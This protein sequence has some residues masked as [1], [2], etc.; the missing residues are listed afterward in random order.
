MENSLWCHWANYYVQIVP[1]VATWPNHLA[2]NPLQIWGRSWPICWCTQMWHLSVLGWYTINMFCSI[3]TSLHIS[4]VNLDTNHKSLLLMILLGSLKWVNTCC[5]ER[6][7]VLS[8]L[9]SS[10]HGTKIAALVQSWLVTVSIE[11]NPC[12]SGNLVM[13]LIVT[14]SKGIASSDPTVVAL[15][16][17]WFGSTITPTLCWNV[18]ST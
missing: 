4:H 14:V 10:M 12:D 3:P 17:T 16:K 13:K 9:T 8:A 2:C 5:T 18:I 1:V 7:A 15:T 11:S 6:A